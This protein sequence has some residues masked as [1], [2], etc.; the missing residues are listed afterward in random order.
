[1]TI[2]NIAALT[3]T[4]P[5]GTDTATVLGYYQAGDGGGGTFYWDALSTEDAD[6]GTIFLLNGSSAPGRW[7]RLYE[8]PLNVKWFGA[9][10]DGVTDDFAAIQA[11]INYRGVLT[12]GSTIGEISARGA[13][14][15]VLLPATKEGYR[16]TAP[17]RLPGYCALTGEVGGG[18]DFLGIQQQSALIADFASPY[19]WA[20]ETD[21]Y[22]SA[23]GTGPITAIPYDGIAVTG[24]V[25]NGWIS[26]CSG[27]R[28]EYVSIVVPSGKRLFG[29]IRILNGGGAKIRNCFVFGA[30]IGILL[31]ACWG[32][33]EVQAQTLT[34][35][36]GVIAMNSNNNCTVNGYYDRVDVT[37]LPETTTFLQEVF[38]I[39]ADIPAGYAAKT[40]GFLNNYSYGSSS[41]SLIT[42]HWDVGVAVCNG[43]YSCSALYAEACH[44]EAIMTFTAHAVFNEVTGASN[45]KTLRAGTLSDL[46]FG[47]VDQ[48]DTPFTTHDS[49]SRYQSQ[50]SVPATIAA[51]YPD[52]NIIP[53]VE[54][55]VIYLQST[56]SDDNHGFLETCPVKTLA[57]A[58]KRAMAGQTPYYNSTNPAEQTAAAKK[59][60]ILDTANYS[61]DTT[62]SLESAKVVIVG[63]QATLTF[64]GSWIY[65]YDAT[66]VLRNLNI[67]N[68]APG[69]WNNMCI[70]T[71]EGSNSLTFESCTVSLDPGKALVGLDYYG[72][73]MLHVSVNNTTI[74][75]DSSSLVV[76]TSY[77]NTTPHF[78]TYIFGNQS[79]LASG[80]AGRS[81]KGINLPAAWIIKSNA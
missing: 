42:E 41:T 9:K 73:S 61:L 80:L 6:Q 15:T 2:T 60:V 5:S 68:S 77:A 64:G 54:R 66:L 26:A 75:G 4:T 63:G 22:M 58:L 79:A 13:G 36:A 51:F 72:A 67:V 21:T 32:A 27:V 53:R 19:H 76:Q 45:G 56:G 38:P 1:M 44:D 55:D 78:L 37:P 40:F 62:V 31:S 46:F 43:T 74:S 3:S 14:Y 23:A 48:L 57:T 25:G 39:D 12:P 49:I 50:I 28:V 35:K 81:D 20:I 16:I 65:L 17:V 47:V 24:A 59:I 7:K 10:G 8:P 30:D 52:R 33:T 29:G 69:S 34:Y 71:T 18:Y 11:T 70:W